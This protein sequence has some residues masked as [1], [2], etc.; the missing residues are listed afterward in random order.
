MSGWRWGVLAV[1]AAAPVWAAEPFVAADSVA[2]NTAQMRKLPGEVIWWKVN[3]PD[4]AWNNRNVHLFYPTANVYRAGP[5]RLLAEAPDP[6]IAAFE[7]ETPNGR[8]PFQAF[9][10]SVASTTM[11]VVLLHRGRIVYEHYPRQQAHEKPI[12][13]SVTKALVGTMVAI[14]EDRGLVDVGLPIDHYIP[15]LKDGDYAGIAIR[16][17]LDMA[18]GVN[19]WDEY[20]SHDACYHHYSAAIGEDTH[21][22]HDPDDPY[23]FVAT[24]DVGRFAEPGTSYAY[25][26]VD[27]F[28][29]GWLVE[30][31]TRMPFQDAFSE[32]VWT[33]IG[34]ESDASILAGRL[35]IPLHSGGLLARVRDLARFGLLF[36][37]SY[38]VVSDEK[39][40]SDRYVEAILH[41]GNPALLRNARDGRQPDPGVRHNV[42]QWD[43]V[44]DNDDFTKGGFAGQGL[45]INPRRDLV[46][47]WTGYFNAEGRDDNLL[48]MVRAIWA[49][50]YGDEET[51]VRK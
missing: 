51:E 39:V 41:G 43:L 34:A 11:G 4:M 40:I 7:V 47:V 14:L 31:V 8:M 12:Y 21:H 22:P 28:V 16:H 33:R 5:V 26:G 13:W 25:S 32:A 24:L 3:G 46:A 29:L 50:L 15:E 23:G 20:E 17:V 38:A 42:Y 30:R 44:F 35:G 36:T 1:L 48:A 37:P 19:C 27:T 18:S 9:L 45:L 49:D 6:R 10:D 2:T